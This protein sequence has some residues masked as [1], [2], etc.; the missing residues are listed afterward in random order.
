MAFKLELPVLKEAILSAFI[1]DEEKNN[2]F[3]SSCIT[4]HASTC[5]TLQNEEVINSHFI[6]GS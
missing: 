3:G 4:L 5:I 1:A 6:F 2:W